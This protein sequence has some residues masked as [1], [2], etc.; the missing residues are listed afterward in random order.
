MA[1][2]LIAIVGM[3]VGLYGEASV[4]MAGGLE[5]IGDREG[6]VFGPW[7]FPD[8]LRMLQFW[9]VGFS[10]DLGSPSCSR[11]FVWLL[12]MV[13]TAA[14]GRTRWCKCTACTF[15]L[16]VFGSELRLWGR[17]RNTGFCSSFAWVVCA[18]LFFFYLTVL[19]KKKREEG[20]R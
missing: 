3:V 6:E 4:M 13:A 10:C 15:G 8:C 5:V 12:G 20:R 14:R 2:E 16:W 1:S 19:K 17:R 7:W 9:L 11:R 18:L